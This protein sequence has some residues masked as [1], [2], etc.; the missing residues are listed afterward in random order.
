MIGAADIDALFVD[1]PAAAR[2]TEL[3][4]L[5]RHAGEM[6]VERELAALPTDAPTALRPWLYRVA[7]NVGA[8]HVAKDKRRIRTWVGLED[9]AEASLDGTRKERF[10]EVATV[11]LLVIDDLGMRK[12]PNTAAEDL[13][14]LVM[15]RYERASTLITSN[16]PVDDWGKLLGDNAAVRALLDRLL[17][18]AHVLKCGPKSFRT[19]AGQPT[20]EVCLVVSVTRKQPA[21]QLRRGEALPASLD[22][23][24]ID[25]VETGVIRAL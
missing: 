15:R 18:H 6:E 3:F 8:S 21:A 10:A 22:G 7:H 4:D 19:R 24:P 5:P 11:P 20:T 12:L 23:V 9:L 13:L 25:V 17:H 2:K 16:R 14:E 1:V